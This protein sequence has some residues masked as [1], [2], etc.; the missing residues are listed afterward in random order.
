MLFN[1]LPGNPIKQ[2]SAC[3]A[4]LGGDHH[5]NLACEHH[6]GILIKE[7]METRNVSPTWLAR[8]LLIANFHLHM[9]SVARTHR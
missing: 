7:S 9:Q 1:H 3:S 5:N 8:W 2:A 4:W 6:L